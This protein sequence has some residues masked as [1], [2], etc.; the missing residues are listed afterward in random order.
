MR[1]EIVVSLCLVIILAKSK[2]G[3]WV[4]RAESLRGIALTPLGVVGDIA[5]ENI[6]R[7]LCGSAIF[8]AV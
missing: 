5:F 2:N 8:Q 1:K 3:A 7:A 6:A 4:H